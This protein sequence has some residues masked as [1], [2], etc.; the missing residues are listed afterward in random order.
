VV[1]ILFDLS[2]VAYPGRKEREIQGR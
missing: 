2:W 1:L